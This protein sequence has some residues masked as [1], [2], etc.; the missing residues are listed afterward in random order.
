MFDRIA[1]HI[2]QLLPLTYRT[3]Y[4]DA[5]GTRRL[6]VWRMWFGRCFDVTDVAIA[7]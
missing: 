5:G 1:W 4:T 3:T 7:S 2:K 6:A